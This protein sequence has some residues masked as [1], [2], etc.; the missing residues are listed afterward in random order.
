M[1]TIRFELQG[2]VHTLHADRTTCHA[3]ARA[4]ALAHRGVCATVWSG[5]TCTHSYHF[6]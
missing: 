1:Y 4:V 3:T 2:R 6:N 5:E